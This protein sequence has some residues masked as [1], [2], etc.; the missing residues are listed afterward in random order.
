MR[1]PLPASLALTTGL[2]T[3]A[4]AGPAA[5]APA[6]VNVD[7]NLFAS[8]AVTVNQGEA[9]TWKWVGSGHN[10]AFTAGPEKIA[11]TDFLNKGATWAH[12]FNTPG[13]YKYVCEAHS[14]MAGTVTVVAADGGS[15]PSGSGTAPAPSN[16]APTPAGGTA[17]PTSGPAGPVTAGTAGVDA[18]APTLSSV[19]FRRNALRLRVSEASKLVIR[20]VRTGRSGHVV[21][22]KTVSAKAGANTI[23]LRRWMRPGRYRVSVTAID[24][25]GNLSR[26]ARL[27]LTVRR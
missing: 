3:L 21:A 10:V 11:K 25:A 1:F 23:A 27:K 5:A 26:V 20:Y 16:G 17:Q 18:A 9:V 8:D 6:T 24:A 7:D 2:A 13:T 12:T 15:A 14:K 19:R 4:L 22:K